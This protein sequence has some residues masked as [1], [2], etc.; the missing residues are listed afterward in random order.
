MFLIMSH[1]MGHDVTIAE[2]GLEAV[3]LLEKNNAFDLV[4]ILMGISMPIMDGIMA[5]R[6]IRSQDVDIPII[7]LTAHTAGSDKQK[8]IDAGMNDIVLKPIRG[9]DIMSVVNRFL[10]NND[11]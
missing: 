1:A 3:E 7:A 8:C 9:K 10:P 5:T 4:L 11:A 6:K 2:N